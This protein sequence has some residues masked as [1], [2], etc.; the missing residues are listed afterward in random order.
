MTY[1]THLA[2]KLINLS[3]AAPWRVSAAASV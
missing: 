1:R 2:S 3:Y